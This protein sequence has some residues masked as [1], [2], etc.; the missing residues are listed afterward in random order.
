MVDERH[1]KGIGTCMEMEW[2]AVVLLV[3]YITD[4]RVNYLTVGTR[5]E[6]LI[7][8]RRDIFCQTIVSR[9][10]LCLFCH[11]IRLYTNAFIYECIDVYVIL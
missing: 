3:G 5:N 10:S 2:Y 11:A 4:L 1:S 7:D 9:C 8:A 6:I